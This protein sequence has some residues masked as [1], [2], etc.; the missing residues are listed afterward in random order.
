MPDIN[1][2]H[3]VTLTPQSM[4]TAFKGDLAS[5][6]NKIIEGKILESVMANLANRPGFNPAALSINFGLKW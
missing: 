5:L 4:S 1:V 2:P 6:N 3:P